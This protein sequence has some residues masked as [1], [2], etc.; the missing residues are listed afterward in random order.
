MVAVVVPSPA[1]S[2]VFD[3]TSRTIWAPMFMNLSSSSISLATVTPSL[4]V[5]GAP[6]R[7][8][9]HHV[10]ALGA[11]GDTYGIGQNVDALEHAFPGRLRRKL[12]SFA[13]IG[14]TLLSVD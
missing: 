5:R 9:E 7:F 14:F 1:S 2:L 6:K 13:D 4:V 10:A 8:V 12:T 11:E 3:A